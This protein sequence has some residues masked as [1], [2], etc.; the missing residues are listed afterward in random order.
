M[1]SSPASCYSVCIRFKLCS[2]APQLSNTVSLYSS[3]NNTD[4]ILLPYS[5]T[6]KITRTVVNAKHLQ[7]ELDELNADEWNLPFQNTV[8]D[9]WLLSNSKSKHIIQKYLFESSC[10]FNIPELCLRQV[11][12]VN[13][14]SV[15]KRFTSKHY[16]MV[17]HQQ[18]EDNDS[19]YSRT[20]LENT[21]VK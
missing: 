1:Q 10:K 18:T 11:T 9:C 5:P 8:Y 2:S 14:Y 3:L 4:H 16:L 15:I 6:C 7:T 21:H 20:A 13:G 12:P 17:S 19:C